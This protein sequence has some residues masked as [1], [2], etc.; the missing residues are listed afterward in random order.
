MPAEG[1]GISWSDITDLMKVLHVIQLVDYCLINYFRVFQV[2]L[3]LLFPLALS[4]L[5]VANL[6]FARVFFHQA[7]CVA[8]Q[9]CTVFF[10]LLLVVFGS[11]SNRAVSLS[12]HAAFH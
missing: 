2:Y 7:P 4:N 11:S 6:P 8:L 5:S 3:T 9:N 12:F 10:C 1:G